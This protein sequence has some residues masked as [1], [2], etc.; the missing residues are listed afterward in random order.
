MREPLVSPRVVGVGLT[1][2]DRL[3]SRALSLLGLDFDISFEQEPF[4]AITQTLTLGSR[5]APEQIDDLKALGITHV[6][7][8]LPESERQS[9]AFLGDDFETLFLPLRDGIH[10]DIGA[11]FP[12]FFE[13]VTSAGQGRVLVHC[14]VGVSRSATLVT[15]HLMK[16][17][18]IRFYEAYHQVRTRRAQVLPNVGFASQLQRFE[19]T[20]IPEPRSDGYTSLT[21]YLKEVCNVPVEIEVLQDL[22]ELHEYDALPAIRA[23]FGDEVPR[24]IQGVRL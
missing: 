7:S 13:F 11:L 19:R 24:V 10:E 23:I 21:R 15:A 16:T 9:V 22:L 4:H 14:E 3:T 18:R 8:C 20:L 2:F 5:P 17:D 1:L 6:V 12:E